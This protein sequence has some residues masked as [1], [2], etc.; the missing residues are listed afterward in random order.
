MVGNFL[1]LDLVDNPDV[2]TLVTN[3]LQLGGRKVSSKLMASYKWRKKNLS[4][5]VMFIFYTSV[6]H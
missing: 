4:S 5:N 2:G 1:S 3:L 6:L